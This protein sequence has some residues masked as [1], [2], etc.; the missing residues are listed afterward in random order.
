M[1]NSTKLEIDVAKMQENIKSI[2]ES[3]ELIRQDIRS[4]R[5]DL[6]TNYVTKEE[7]KPMQRFIQGMQGAGVVILM[8]ILGLLLSHV[9]PGISL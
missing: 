5:A 6:Q 2:C 8:G 1:S 3:V 7:I 9:I 4:L